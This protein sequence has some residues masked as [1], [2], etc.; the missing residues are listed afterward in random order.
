MS[1]QQLPLPLDKVLTYRMQGQSAYVLEHNTD[2]DIFVLSIDYLNLGNNFTYQHMVNAIMEHPL[3]EELVDDIHEHIYIGSD[4]VI[5]APLNFGF[6]LKEHTCASDL[7][8]HL[9]EFA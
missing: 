1:E 2:N 9:A 6:N 7:L 5:C 4:V 3:G 8:G